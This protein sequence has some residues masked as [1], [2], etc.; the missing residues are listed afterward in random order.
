[1]S[2]S[3]SSE[4]SSFKGKNETNQT[5]MCLTLLQRNT[6]PPC[7]GEKRG[8]R[9]QTEPG[10]FLG[11]RRRPWGRYA[12][13]IRDPTTKERHWLGTFD[14]A[15][16]AAL[17]YDRAAI[18]MKGNQARTNFIYSDHS[19]INFHTLVS[20]PINHV[21]LQVQPL[22]QP[23]QILNNT[24]T[25]QTKQQ[26]NQ[27]SFSHHLNN[28]NLSTLNNDMIVS[29]DNEKTTNKSS[30]HSHDDNFFFSSDSSNSG[31]LECIVPDN[32]FNPASSNRSNSRNSNVSV[33]SDQKFT[34]KVESNQVSMEGQSHF[35]ITSFS[36]EMPSR[37]SN[38]SN[39]YPS[40]EIIGQ[41]FWDWN[42]SELSAIFNNNSLSV[43]DECCMDTTFYP[44]YPMMIEALSPSYGIMNEQ[45][46]S[47]TNCSPS[48]D[49]GYNLF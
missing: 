24:I 41:E 10:R 33:S 15:Q 34:S 1:M 16:E 25:T 48:L 44:N 32:C 7:S 42:S 27:N 45:A 12:A 29:V 3:K 30:A 13:E 36:E 38:F 40:D 22:L 5:Q 43:E 23:S 2:T 19:T 17:A 39:Y 31:Y 20:S 9:K 4:D 49:L 6:S 28:E 14:T 11:V 18:S 26:I 21:Q 35:G 8:R 47:S 46:A 37:V